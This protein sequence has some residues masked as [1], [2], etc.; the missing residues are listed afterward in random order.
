[1]EYPFSVP[2][3]G[4]YFLLLRVKSDEPASNH[5]S[6]VLCGSMTARFDRGASCEPLHRGGWSLAAHNSQMSLICLQ[7]FEL[8]AGDH[9]VKLAPRES[10]HIDLARRHR[11]SGI[12]RR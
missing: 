4:K 3:T 10:V 8:A 6:S 11:Q 1:M 2:K 5:D 7:A 12:V 9:I